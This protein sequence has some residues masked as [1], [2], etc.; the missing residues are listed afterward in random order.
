MIALPALTDQQLG[1][2]N[3]C[4]EHLEALV[5]GFRRL[6]SDTSMCEHRTR[7]AFA[8]ELALNTLRNEVEEHA[9]IRCRTTQ[10]S[11]EAEQCT[12]RTGAAGLYG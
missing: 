2:I 11:E 8:A 4:T 7:I 3:K 6:A 5:D 12:P 10:L 1:L 9:E